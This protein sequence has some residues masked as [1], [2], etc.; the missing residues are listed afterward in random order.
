MCATQMAPYITRGQIRL[1]AT[2]REG[3]MTFRIM[4]EINTRTDQ[5][6]TEE[7]ERY[8]RLGNIL[9]FTNQPHDVTPPHST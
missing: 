6:E 4:H 1:G 3:K 8:A 7:G 5:Y 2:H 9:F